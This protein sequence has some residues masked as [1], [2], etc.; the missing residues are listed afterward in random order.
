MLAPSPERAMVAGGPV[1]SG[2]ASC[3]RS[4]TRSVAI[5]RPPQPHAEAGKDF[6]PVQAVVGTEVRDLG[7]R[8]VGDRT[9]ALGVHDP[10]Q[11]YTRLQILP[12]LVEDVTSTVLRREHL[13]RQVGHDITETLGQ[14][15]CPKA[16]APDK[17][18]VRRAN[19]AT[20]KTKAGAGIEHVSQAMLLHGANE[21]DEQAGANVT[22]TAS[23][24]THADLAVDELVLPA[25][26]RRPEKVD[27][28]RHRASRRCHLRYRS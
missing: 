24:W 13:H 12:H 15:P 9:F 28:R 20:G 1:R 25:V 21:P 22:V 4:R 16:P 26:L 8:P 27:F 3:R 17:A 5:R 14:L 10:H 7:Q 19:V 2:P 11:S 23:R 18:D 6:A